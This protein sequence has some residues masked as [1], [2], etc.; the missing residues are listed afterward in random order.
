[1][2]LLKERQRLLPLRRAPHRRESG[3]EGVQRFGIHLLLKRSWHPSKKE[4]KTS[5]LHDFTR[6]LP[7]FLGFRKL[8]EACLHAFLGLQ[9]VER[10]L[11]Q[12]DVAQGAHG[13]LDPL[14]G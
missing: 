13:H 4:R 12:V 14:Y 2:D 11:P 7:R 3:V 10:L 6:R 8:F 9:H 5:T 1:M